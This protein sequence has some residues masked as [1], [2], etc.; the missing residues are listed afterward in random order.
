MTNKSSNKKELHD[1]ASGLL[2]EGLSIRIEASGYSM[3]PTIKP[4]TII[5]IDP[6]ASPDDLKPGDII[7]WHRADGIIG[8]RLIRAY[9]KDDNYW[10]ITRGDSSLA[11]DPPVPFNNLAGKVVLIETGRSKYKPHAT[12]VIPEWKYAFNRKLV[13]LVAH[14]RKW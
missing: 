6:V 12:G 2:K 7:S 4:G 13:W 14:Y 9:I 8:H 11:A 5:Y 3:Y 10:L 1:I